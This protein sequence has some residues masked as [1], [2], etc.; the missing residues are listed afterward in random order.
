VKESLYAK[1]QLA[2]LAGFSDRSFPSLILNC[3]LQM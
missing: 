3:Y 2:G 1:N